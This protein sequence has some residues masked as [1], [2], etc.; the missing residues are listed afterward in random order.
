LKRMH[1]SSARLVACEELQ[2][3]LIITDV[4]FI[5]LTKTFGCALMHAW[6]EK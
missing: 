1:G 4:R 2:D 6:S 5:T 3:F